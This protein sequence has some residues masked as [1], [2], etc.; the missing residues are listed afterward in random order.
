MK[1]YK[2][3]NKPWRIFP[4]IYG[5][6]DKSVLEVILN[7]CKRTEI[8]P[9]P[10]KNAVIIILIDSFLKAIFEIIFIPL[11]ISNNPVKI[12]DIKLVSILKKLHNGVNNSSNISSKWLDFKID[13]MLE[14][15]TTNPP[16]IRIVEIL[17]V[18]LSDK[19]S[20]KLEKVA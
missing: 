6:I 8:P 5:L 9:K 4:Y 20:P 16:I 7:T 19:I 11:V 3:A 1:V 15:I 2:A 10:S 13:I 14:N 12:P 18:I 17:L